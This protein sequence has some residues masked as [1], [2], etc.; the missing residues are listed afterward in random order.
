MKKLL[1]I[2]AAV[3]SF[4]FAQ[5]EVTLKVIDATD[6][7]GTEIAE[8]P[9]EG[10]SNGEARHV[11]PLESLK[12][13]DYS[14]SFTS[15]TNKTN[16]PAYYW[17]MTDKEDIRTI[18]LYG[19]N[20]MTISAP[21]G[22]TMKQI[23]FK[24]SNGNASANPTATNGTLVVS[25]KT[26]MTWTGEASEFTITYDKTFRITEMTVYV[27]GDNPEEPEV[28]EVEK[29][30]NIAAFVAKCTTSN[31]PTLTIDAPVTVTYQ[32]GRYLYIKDDSG[33]MA[34]YGDI[35]TKYA[36]GDVIPAGIT[37]VAQNYSNGVFQMNSPQDKTFLAAE[38][39]DSVKPHDIRIGQIITSFVSRYI[40]LRD[41]KVEQ[42]MNAGVVKPNY[43]TIRDNEND[44]ILLYNQFSN[45]DFYE[46]VDVPT[47]DDMNV[48][49]IITVYRGVP[50][51]YPVKVVPSFLDFEFSSEY[52]IVN[53]IAGFRELCTSIK[54]IKA[55]INNP[56]IVT[57]QYGNE[58][59]IKDDSA[60]ISVLFDNKPEF[61]SGEV[62]SPGIIGFA[63]ESN[64]RGSYMY[65]I[66]NSFN[67]SGICDNPNPKIL[68]S[69]D[70]YSCS[71]DEYIQFNDVEI[72]PVFDEVLQEPIYGRYNILVRDGTDHCRI[73][74]I[75]NKFNVN[76]MNYI[77]KHRNLYGIVGLEN[78]LTIYPIRMEDVSSSH[79]IDTTNE[80]S[81][82]AYYNLYG[83]RI[84]QYQ[85]GF[86][87]QRI[88]TK[89]KK[90]YNR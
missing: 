33:V 23:E 42:Y 37:G 17:S 26:A 49:A 71:K 36:N 16:A 32:N 69:I 14:F 87:I 12:L 60:S 5:A 4:T 28:P 6:I 38:R 82:P 78:P 80:F 66:E 68:S 8:K 88:G 27:N 63:C 89:Y 40:V 22:T 1:L 83:A 30:A 72:V 64:K 44:E 47:G 54:P 15:G 7:K 59:Y 77:G 2:L 76:T 62:I 74:K 81:E 79:I 57:Y 90:T 48:Y 45:E 70:N 20:T 65:A 58:V 84:S 86:I 35:T 25:G 18:R 55:L 31:Y 51:L 67:K 43:Y 11:Q 56:V 13:G 10:S 46:V 29:V 21:A 61:T 53:S 3:A 9:G 52:E 19:G 24:G 75:E 39:G 85:K 73:I 34:V 41:V 50:N